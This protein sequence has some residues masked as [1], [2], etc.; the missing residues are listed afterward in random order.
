[1]LRPVIA[2]SLV[3][4]LLLFPGCSAFQKKRAPD[5]GLNIPKVQREFRAAWVATVANINWPSKPGLS[6]EQQQAEAIQ[7]LDTLVKNN[8]NAV[9]F[10]VRPQCDAFFPS[11]YEPWS[12][13]L[14]G[15]QGKAPDP[16]YDPLAF[17][18]EEAHKRG[19]ELHCW[20][21]PYRAHHPA[22]GE[23]SG[24]SIVKTRADLSK[25]VGEYHW[26]DPA[27]KG[28]Q[29]HSYAVVMDVLRRYDIDGVHFDDY[30]YPYGDG[31]FPDDE[32]WA[33]YR[34]KGG[35]LSR[36]DWRRDQVNRFIKRLHTG[37]K[38]E[39]PRVKFGLSPFGIWRPGYPESIRGLDQYSILYADAKLW[40]NK[41]WIDY[42]SPQL[43]WPTNQIPQSF[44]VLLGWWE[45]E[46]TKKRHFWPGIIIGDGRDEKRTDETINQIMITRGMLPESPGAIHFSIS[47]IN[48]AENGLAETLRKGPYAKP[49]LVP[50]TPWL[51]NKAP[52][53]P[54]VNATARGEDLGLTLAP[55]NDEAVFR[56]VVYM[57]YGE[58]WDYTVCNSGDSGI[59]IPLTRETVIPARSGGEPEKRV[60]R[61]TLFAVSAVDRLG[62]ESVRT[63][64]E[65]W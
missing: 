40:L 58:I 4:L 15:E 2:S 22:G 63:V 3:A 39:K 30:F 53:A 64:V 26:L 12:Y 29:D 16:Y 24:R 9:I 6:T 62:N 27:K 10:Q 5:S 44:P 23:I 57:R 52:A 61:L 59:R 25:K 47:G 8:F 36:E 11:Q 41:G 42:W 65:K 55:G 33:E 13:F 50:T 19:L 48:D 43:Y 7:L 14:T 18:I 31:S 49:A 35:K 28:T 21:N 46:N 32:T 17:W 60:D 20:F 38:K 51:D 1:M 37:I 56:W 34:G 45:K 54:V